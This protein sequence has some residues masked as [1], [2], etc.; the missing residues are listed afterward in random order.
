MERS[1]EFI[2]SIL[3]IIKSGNAYVPI[4]QD[5]LNPGHSGSFPKKSRLSFMLKDTKMKLVITKK[6]FIMMTSPVKGEKYY[7]WMLMI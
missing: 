5:T 2:V 4:D 6:R 1:I 7:V 3:G